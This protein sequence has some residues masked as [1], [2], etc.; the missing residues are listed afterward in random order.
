MVECKARKKALHF[1]AYIYQYKPHK[2]ALKYAAICL[3]L[4]LPLFLPHLFFSMPLALYELLFGKQKLLNFRII[5]LA[6]SPLKNNV[7]QNE[8]NICLYM[9][10]VHT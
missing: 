8:K 2:Y 7:Q 3:K 9:Q 6:D 5:W 1:Y 4:Y 10:S